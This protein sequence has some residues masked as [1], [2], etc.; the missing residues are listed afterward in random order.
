M[1]LYDDCSSRL[2]EIILL[3]KFNQTNMQW[4]IALLI[5]LTLAAVINTEKKIII[6]ERQ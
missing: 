6:A 3:R 1:V 2:Y 4:A 5:N